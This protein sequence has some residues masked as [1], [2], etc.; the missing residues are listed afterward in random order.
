MS[1]GLRINE[2]RSGLLVLGITLAI[3]TVLLAAFAGYCYRYYTTGQKLPIPIPIPI[4]SASASTVETPITA[5][6][7]NEHVVAPAKP[8]YLSIDTLGVENA[9][10]LPV[11]VTENNELATPNNIHDVGWYEESASPGDGSPA[12]LIDGHNGGPTMGGV[13]QNLE[14]MNVGD[15]ITLERGDGSQHTYVVQ[16]NKSITVE[17]LNNGVMKEMASSIDPRYQGLN[18]ISCT[19]NWIPQKKT[20]DSRQVVRA[21]LKV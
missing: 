16:E 4:A 7:I 12:V 17:E 13:F 1:T 9:R 19:G 11:G 3:T 6:Q 20:Y 14:N 15:E 10:V 2:P 21:V 5:Q 18:I 8:R